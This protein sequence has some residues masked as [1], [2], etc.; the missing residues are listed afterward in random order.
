MAVSNRLSSSDSRLDFLGIKSRVTQRLLKWSLLAGFFASL[1]VSAGEAYLSY[2]ER[3]E[4]L[5]QH[6][7]SIGNYVAPSLVLSLWAFNADQT[8]IQLKGFTHL[9]D[10][11]AVRLQ[12]E[13]QPEI[14]YGQETITEVFERSFPLIYTEEGRQHRLGTLTLI[15]DMQLEREIMIRRLLINFVGNTLVIVLVV[16]IVLFVYH[17]LVRKRLSEVASE[18]E[19]TDPDDLRQ[20]AQHL[21]VVENVSDEIDELVTSIVKLKVTGGQALRNLDNRNRELEKLLAELNESKYL[22]QSIIDTAPIRVFWKDRDLRYKGCNPQFARDAGKGSPEQVIG[23]DDYEMGWKAQADLYRNDDMAIMSLGAGKLGYEEPQTTPEGRK[24][25]LRTSK[26]PLQ[27]RQ[28]EVI[29]ILGIYDDIT[30]AK[31]ANIEL[32][33]HRLHLEELVDA[34]TKDLATAKEFAEAANRAK[35]TFLANMSHELRTPMNAIMGMASLAMRRA[36]D[37]K[38]K[39]QLG[40]IDSASKHLLHVINDILDI[41]KIEAERLKLEQTA[42]KIGAVFENT[43]SLITHKAAEKTIDIRVDMPARFLSLTVVGDPLRVGQVFL[44]LAANAVKFTDP[45]GAIMLRASLTEETPDDLLMLWEVQ[46]SGIGIDPEAQKRLFTAFEQADNSMTRKYGGTGLGLAI[47][48]RLVKLMG[49]EIG[50]KSELGK[51]STFWFTVRL[52]KGIEAETTEQI[53]PQRS[54]DH[55]LFDEYS[56]KRILLAEDEPI[57]QEVARGLMEEVGLM[58]DLASNG[59]EAVNQARQNRYDLIVMDVQMPILNGLN[60]TQLIR[61]DSLNTTT[62]ILAMTANA[63]DEDRQACLDAGMDDHIGKPIDPDSLYEILLTWLA[64]NQS[65]P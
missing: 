20:T 65:H 32:E 5:D 21:P 56:G 55:V 61:S 28:G 12:Q 14:R 25:W 53:L 1:L 46:D 6:Y 39:D 34:R 44:N 54:A 48:K 11:S 58:I 42:F 36:D 29:G 9:L 23:R 24:I 64:N 7:L 30:Q 15:K 33:Q 47:S 4:A 10:V 57:N 62:P 63:F 19:N 2:Q 8:E 3:V 52:P 51:G 17:S 35:S 45:G 16:L 60:A 40:K 22:L 27:N 37:P 31:S 41:S 49:G 13:N 50:V 18:L 38:L 26:V 59:Q 43:L